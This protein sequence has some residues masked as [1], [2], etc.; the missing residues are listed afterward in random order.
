MLNSY[1]SQYNF[2]FCLPETINLWIDFNSECDS[3]RVT[4]KH[5]VI[6]V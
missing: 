1:L 4:I 3:Y 5:L 2:F 6:R